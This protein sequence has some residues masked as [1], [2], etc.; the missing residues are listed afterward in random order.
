[1]STS[2]VE[3]FYPHSFSCDHISFLYC[4]SCS[5]K[6][7]SVCSQTGGTLTSSEITSQLCVPVCQIRAIWPE[8]F[9][10]DFSILKKRKE[11]VYMFVKLQG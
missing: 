5:H 1:M 7:L 3:N 9:M 4:A 10:V 2:G 11:T 6:E 8:M